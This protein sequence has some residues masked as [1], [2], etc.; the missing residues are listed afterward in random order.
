MF[1]ARMLRMGCRG[2]VG[3]AAHRTSVGTGGEREVVRGEGV[4]ATRVGQVCSCAG[5]AGVSMER[6]I[7]PSLPAVPVVFVKA[8]SLLLGCVGAG[9][10][11]RGRD[12]GNS[13]GGLGRG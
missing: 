5:L 4:V 2:R 12:W 7:V 1:T 9:L 6:L 8:G 3:E 11:A 13:V 10:L